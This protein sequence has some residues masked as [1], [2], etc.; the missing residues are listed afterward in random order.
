MNLNNCIL[1]LISIILILAILCGKDEIDTF[2]STLTDGN[3]RNL[4]Q[5]KSDL[6]GKHYNVQE[7][8][9]NQKEAAN[10]L[11]HIDNTIIKFIKLLQKEYPNRSEIQRLNRYSSHNIL[12]GHPINKQGS[13]SYSLNKGEKVVFC[14]RSKRDKKLHNRNL[15]IFVAIH[16]M[17]HIMSVTYGHN[18]EF[19]QNFQFLLK[20]AVKHRIYRKINFTLNP[21]EYCGMHVTS[22]PV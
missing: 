18:D 3:F 14:L 16:E 6:N 1:I 21:Q 22:S 9:P 11:A 4:I 5:I 17:A 13:T 2:V 7:N 12:E 20:E 19:M 15:L 8:L 10:M